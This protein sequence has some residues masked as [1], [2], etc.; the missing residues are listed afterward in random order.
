MQ[1]AD[2]DLSANGTNEFSIGIGRKFEV[3]ASGNF[4]GGT[5][6]IRFHKNATDL[7]PVGVVDED[8]F[9]SDFSIGHWNV[10]GAPV[11]TVELT[12][13][14]NPDVFLNVVRLP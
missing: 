14:T 8:S 9:T 7:L 12:G 6:N 4:G 5:I 13:A 11:I 1:I 3:T 2:M 10:G